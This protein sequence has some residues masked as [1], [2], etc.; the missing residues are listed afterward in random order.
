MRGTVRISCVRC[1]SQHRKCD[2]KDPCEGCAFAGVECVYV[3]AKRGKNGKSTTES[4]ITSTD[5]EK[6]A[7]HDKKVSDCSEKA[8]DSGGTKLKGD[9]DQS[10]QLLT[11]RQAALQDCHPQVRQSLK[12]P[13]ESNGELSQKKRKLNEPIS[14][15]SSVAGSSGTDDL[16]HPVMLLAGM[17][18]NKGRA[19]PGNGRIQEG[20]ISKPS[21]QPS[22]LPPPGFT[23]KNGR[24]LLNPSS[25]D[26]LSLQRSLSQDYN[27]SA[28]KLLSISPPGNDCHIATPP[29][30]GYLPPSQSSSPSVVSRSNFID[31]YSRHQPHHRPVERTFSLGMTPSFHF[32]GSQSVSELRTDSLP[33]Y[34]PSP[35]WSDA[36]IMA[37]SPKISDLLSPPHSL[38]SSPMPVH[39]AHSFPSQNLALP[40]PAPASGQL[41]PSDLRTFSSFSP[42]SPDLE[43]VSSWD[44]SDLQGRYHTSRA[45]LS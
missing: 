45:N 24:S 22:S 20:D 21:L 41:R 39:R 32:E 17:Y 4:K 33:P 10:S 1:R 42:F 44:S 30:L 37:S 38:Y 7:D 18:E 40:S 9:N 19:N 5:V 31:G 35:M 15:T 34:I 29:L 25:Q 11:E 16:F 27:F 43:S 2:R 12:R 6:N 36:R 14:S 28:S 26:Q 13:V 8:P 3:K 23:D